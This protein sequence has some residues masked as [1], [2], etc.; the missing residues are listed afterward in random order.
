M[1]VAVALC[2]VAVLGCGRDPQ[3]S[4][5]G[6]RTARAPRLPAS[7][8]P[9]PPPVAT[10]ASEK[11]FSAAMMPSTRLKKIVGETSGSVTCRKRAQAPAP[12]I[13]AASYISCGTPCSP[14][15]KISIVLPPQAFQSPIR[16]I[17]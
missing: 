17:A 3:D 13:S 11:T 10:K 1:L 7:I 5:D 4:A 6:K 12:S 2:G 9:G 16:T 15:R 8:A 14:A